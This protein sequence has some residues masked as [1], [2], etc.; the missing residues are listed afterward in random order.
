MTIPD[1]SYLAPSPVRD[2]LRRDVRTGLE[3][4]AKYLPSKWFYDEVGSKLFDEITRLPEY[5]PTRTERALLAERAA[6]VA[7]SSGAQTLVELGSGTSEKT[8]LLLDALRD[9][10]TLQRFVPVDVDP[11]V[12]ADAAETIAA[13]YPGIDVQP[14]VADFEHHLLHLP[15]GGRRVVVFLGSTIGN[16]DEPGRADFL[17]TVRSTLGEDDSFLLGTDLVKDVGRLVAAYDDAQGVT[18]AFNR[19]VLAVVNSGL[20]ANFDLDAFEHVAL[21]D[22]VNERIEMRLRSVREQVVHVA[23]PGLVV[24]FAEGEELLTEISSK[25]TRERVERE[26]SEAGLQ[27]VSWWSDPA[28]DFGLSLSVPA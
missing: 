8:R 28:D 23:D 16:L 25:F 26:L 17:G 4:T 2:A 24:S 21:W 3:A 20:G 7:A 6:E 5:Y 15:R 12:L 13:E 11:S 10:G 14:V 18:A 22:D 9:A 27:L 1:R 19:N